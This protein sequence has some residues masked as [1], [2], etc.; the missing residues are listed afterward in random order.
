MS[1]VFRFFGAKMED[2]GWNLS[3]EDIVHITRVLRLQDGDEI[4]VADGRGSA[5][6][7]KL[8]RIGKDRVEIAVTKEWQQEAPEFKIAI[9]VGA[10]KPAA[11]D[12]MLPHAVELGVDVIVCFGQKNVA[13][14]RLGDEQVE[15]WRRIAKASFKQ[16]KRMWLPEILVLPDLAACFQHFS[17]WRG[18]VLDADAEAHLLD[19]APMVGHEVAI[20]GGERGLDAE[21]LSMATTAGFRRV[22]IGEHVLRAVT[23]AGI[24]TFALARRR[25]SGKSRRQF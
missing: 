8:H 14:F 11:V 4:E 24:A 5:C 22:A 15:R 25:E 17:G 21:E 6:L 18:Y 2:G 1:H 23:A 19:E 12:E 10:L 3:N 16:C 13:K 9:A 20:I 7:A